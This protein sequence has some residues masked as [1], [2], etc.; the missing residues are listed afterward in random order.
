MSVPGGPASGAPQPV[1]E[2]PRSERHQ[3]AE[4]ARRAGV[5]V[6]VIVLTWNDGPLL[7]TCLDA[8][9]RSEGVDLEVV[10][11]DNGSQP[12]ASVPARV[13][14][15]RNEENRGVAPARNQGVAVSRSPLIC[16]LDSDAVVRPGTI[17]R[18][19]RALEEDH[20]VALAAPVFRGQPPEASGGRAPTLVEKARRGLNLTDTYS[21]IKRNGGTWRVDFAIGACQLFRRAAFDGVGGLDERYFYGPEDIDFCL[22]LRQAGWGVVQV[23]DAEVEHPPRR[24]FRGL[25]TRRGQVHLRAVLHHHWRHRGFTRRVGAP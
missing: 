8:L 3:L 14:L 9:L 11:V 22:R 21:S 12:P 1:H 18:L 19:A 23:A 25:L 6:S 24:R 13:Q 15:L 4:D 5:A 2:P 16:L 7:T 20:Q 17:A 10:V